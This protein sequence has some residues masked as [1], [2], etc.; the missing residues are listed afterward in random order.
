MC[1]HPNKKKKKKKKKNIDKSKINHEV[2]YRKMTKN[3]KY[4]KNYY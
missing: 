2:K 4:S 1:N 3:Q